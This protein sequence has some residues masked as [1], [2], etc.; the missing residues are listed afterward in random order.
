MMPAVH[1]AL[2]RPAIHHI[3]EVILPV[4]PGGILVTGLLF[5][6]PQFSARAATLGI[7]YYTRVSVAGLFAYAV[8]LLLFAWSNHFGVLVSTAAAAFYF[9]KGKH[10][11]KGRGNR[12]VSQNHV[13]RTAAANVLG[14]RLAPSP[15][16]TGF[17]TVGP[18][19]PLQLAPSAVQQYDIDWNDWYD[20]L[21][22]YVLRK[23]PIVQPE[24]P[25]FATIIQAIGWAF[26]VLAL[27]PGLGRHWPILFALIPIVLVLALFHFGVNYVY[28]RYDRLSPIE[29]TARLVAEIRRQEL[30][31]NVKLK[32]ANKSENP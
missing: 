7:G 27:Q 1:V 30:A 3:Y 18:S 15:P 5:A 2:D 10:P 8:G 19:D 26:A 21:Q 31:L 14:D 11:P 24:I 12:I 4:V 6:H 23:K 25:F 28:Y 17:F 13:W 9:R 32:A 16:S 22:D 20:V 29:F